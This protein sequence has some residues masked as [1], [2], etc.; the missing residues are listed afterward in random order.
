MAKALAWVE[1]K[2]FTTENQRGSQGQLLSFFS[3]T[4][5]NHHR[6]LLLRPDLNIGEQVNLLIFQSVGEITPL[7]LLPSERLSRLESTPIIDLLWLT[8]L[9][10]G[11]G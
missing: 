6:W 4:L 5:G 11:S 8:I 3:S 10:T 1:L 2:S 7:V 9:R